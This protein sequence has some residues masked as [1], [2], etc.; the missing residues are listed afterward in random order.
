MKDIDID[1]LEL[2]THEIVKENP[3]EEKLKLYMKK[4]GIKYSKDPLTRI[5]TI[6]EE[7]DFL[8]AE[9]MENE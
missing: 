7:I 6:L 2:L 4:A 8:K 5:H 9:E 3:E 1:L